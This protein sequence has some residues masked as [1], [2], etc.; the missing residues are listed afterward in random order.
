L[1][2]PTALAVAISGGDC[3]L[4]ALIRWYIDTF[5]TISPWQRSKEDALQFLEKHPLGRLMP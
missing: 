4:A 1:K 2:D 5:E 3:T